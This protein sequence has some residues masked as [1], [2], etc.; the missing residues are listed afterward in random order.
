MSSYSE[1][2]TPP[3]TLKLSLYISGWIR[4]FRTSLN[5]FWKTMFFS[6]KKSY[7]KGV[8]SPP[9]MENSIK[10]MFFLLKASLTILHIII[11]WLCTQMRYSM[12]R[13]ILIYL[14]SRAE[15]NRS[16]CGKTS[17]CNFNQEN[18][19]SR[20]FFNTGTIKR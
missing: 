20:P 17:Q 12:T 15:E 4:S 6:T 8:D 2:L 10:R 1:Y 18:A 5:I 13:W 9:L 19:S 3:P 7:G 11:S 14:M 16:P